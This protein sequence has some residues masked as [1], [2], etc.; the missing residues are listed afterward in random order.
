[1]YG[2]DAPFSIDNGPPAQL[3]YGTGRLDT[4]GVCGHANTGFGALF[5]WDLVGDGQHTIQVFDNGV[6]FASATFTVKTLGHEFLPGLS[7]QG[8]VVN[9]DNQI[10]VTVQWQES[11]QCFV[12][13]DATAPI[14]VGPPTVTD[15]GSS[16]PLCE[17]PDAGRKEALLQSEW[18]IFGHF[19]SP[20]AGK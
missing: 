11:C 18:V 15:L 6:Q 8:T 12:I 4:Q 13:V 5:N 17:Q 20:R 10:N 7:G 2:R 19:S 16:L 9:F 14:R 1:M 3:A